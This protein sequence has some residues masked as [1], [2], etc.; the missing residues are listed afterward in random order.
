[1]L[2]WQSRT[3]GL[4]PWGIIHNDHHRYINGCCESLDCSEF[5]AMVSVVKAM[6]AESFVTM[7]V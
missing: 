1:M 5:K 7:I 6:N 2:E 3:D 4:G